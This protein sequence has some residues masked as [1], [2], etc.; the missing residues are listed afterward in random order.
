MAL[1]DL[2]E[3]R[4]RAVL[5]LRSYN[6]DYF[7]EESQGLLL[8]SIA[9]GGKLFHEWGQQDVASAGFSD[10][11]R[12]IRKGL[13]YTETR[14]DQ[15]ARIQQENSSVTEWSDFQRRQL[16]KSWTDPSQRPTSG[17][18]WPGGPDVKPGEG[19]RNWYNPRTKESLRMD[20]DHSYPPG[21]HFDL[22]SRINDDH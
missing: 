16:H 2:I 10:L 21:P 3:E 7:I 8:M 22:M 20:M 13:Q 11:P 5:H 17:F 19:N 9:P 12:H 4:E 1:P 18:I 6:W 14:W 15:A